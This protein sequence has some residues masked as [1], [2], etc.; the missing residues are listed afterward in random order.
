M[1]RLNILLVGD[2]PRLAEAREAVADD[3]VVETVLARTAHEALDCVAEQVFGAILLDL[4]RDAAMMDAASRIRR[5]PHGTRVPLMLLGSRIDGLQLASALGPVDFL[6]PP[7]TPGMLRAR[8]RFLADL[9]G[10]H[11]S[12]HPDAACPADGDHFRALSRSA[13]IAVFQLDSDG[14]CLYTSPRW[15]ATTGQSAAAAEGLG[16]AEAL[17]AGHAERV[18]A[19]WR[20]A[21]ADDVA[22]DEE[23]PIGSNDN[24]GRRWLSVKASPVHSPAG[25]TIGHVG[26]VQDVT[27]CREAER[28]RQDAERQ[29]DEFLAMLAHELR[30]PLAAIGNAASVARTPGLE[31]RRDWSL[32]V[33]SRQVGQLARLIDN[34]TDAARVTLGKIELRT[35]RVDLAQVLRLA[36][37]AAQSDMSPRRQQVE[38]ACD[39]ERL[40]VLGDPARLEQVFLNVLSNASRYSPP[41]TCV[42]VTAGRAAGW[43]TV[44]VRDEGVGLEPA[45]LS[46]VFDLFVQ[47]PSKLDRSQGGLGIGLSL[48]RR[49]VELHG[50]TI[51]AHSDGPGRG[52][53]FVVRLPEALA[54][55]DQHATASEP[56][57]DAPRQRTALIVDDNVDAA[58]ALGLLLESAGIRVVTAH[59][60][61]AALARVAEA[62]PDFVLMDLGLPVLDGYEVASRL[63]AQPEFRDLMLVAVSGYGS[64]QDQR[65]S[66]A[67]GF[68]HHLVKPV[69]CEALFRILGEPQRRAGSA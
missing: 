68:D 23:L 15:E 25:R 54:S 35:E 18:L 32:T 37:D 29:K 44:G 6:V 3:P 42:H 65:R 17:G 59:D 8:L 39:A 43:V 27:D 20:R 69:D 10:V 56:S 14:R 36:V 61:A 41:E 46:R 53:E 28:R 66:A 48:A 31:A 67:A 58:E 11:G 45:M 51:I 60:G 30:N 63:R 52:T 64:E 38:L 2:T 12:G 57:R 16:W 24:G 21:V 5:V 22:W 40:P 13:P 33:I 4:G 50:G 55:E 47:A 49:L 7:V 26:T 62:R 34:L 19:S 9:Q 1:E